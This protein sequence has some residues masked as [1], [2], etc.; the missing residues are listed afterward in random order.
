[1]RKLI[2]LRGAQGCG[3]T[4]LVKDYQPL[5]VSF[6]SFRELHAPAIPTLD[7]DTSLVLSTGAQKKSVQAALGA[8][9]ERMAL[10]MSVVVDNMNLR[11][12]DQAD[13]VRLAEKYQYEVLLVDVQ[14]DI[15][16]EELLRRN[17]TRGNKRIEEA[18]LLDFAAVGRERNLHPD[19]REISRDQLHAE[20]VAR[21][22]WVD[23]N[24]FNR[25][26]VI[27]DIH[28]CADALKQATERELSDGGPIAWVFLGD[29]FDRGPDAAR[30]FQHVRQELGH[31][32][33]A[34]FFIEGN[35]ET[36]MRC[37]ILQDATFS[38]DTLKSREDIHAKGFSDSD[39][40]ELLN[41]TRPFLRFR[42]AGKRF[43]ACHGGVDRRTV[44]GARD[45]HLMPDH[46]FIHG[47]SD[48]GRTYRKRS[49]YEHVG[50]FL[51]GDDSEVTQ[52]HG[53]RNGG[54]DDE[55]L[56][57]D[58]VPGIYN[59]EQGVEEGGHLALAVIDR[60]G[61]ITVRRYTERADEHRA[62]E[63][64]ARNL[65][66]ELAAHPDIHA[67]DLGNGIT[68]YNFTRDA[69]RRG[70][71]DKLSTSA[72][73]LFMRGDKV[74]ARGYEKFFNLGERNGFTREQVLE[75]FEYPVLVKSKVN[76]FL[77]IVAAVDGKLV[78]YT[79]GG[80]TPYAKAGQKAFEWFYEPHLRQ[81][82][83]RLLTQLNVS[84]TFEVVLN[85]DPHIVAESEGVH[86]LD[87]I[88]ND[89]Q[90]RLANAEALHAIEG[91]VGWGAQSL[92][93]RAEN[94]DELAFWLD[95]FMESKDEGAVFTDAAGRW[96]KVKSQHYLRI[97][98]MRSALL[99][100][101]TGT[102]ET[103][104]SRFTAEESV[105]RESGVWDDLPDYLEKTPSGQMA[106]RIPDIVEDA[107]L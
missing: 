39:I 85:N 104:G 13:W 88:V 23:L 95:H 21:T 32:G 86:F 92:A 29:L 25:V 19:V 45:L 55:R 93:Q 67:K 69:F 52:L 63:P 60:T 89:L 14:G 42:F 102:G 37:A 50:E 103:L 54:F 82:L 62:E 105:L 56:P 24:G 9:E 34:V 74:V 81:D 4:T 43:F 15:T 64:K 75:E 87:A 84:L 6:D 31:Y 76:G 72:R 94:R 17:R 22:E 59:L 66:E 53:H 77:M 51:A 106:L 35:H 107:D 27:G 78:Y 46:F 38:K 100:V 71:W 18:L 1:M 33:D 16:D 57:E 5:V 96:T 68:A 48:R 28:S 44:E 8:A 20:I 47:I 91:I 41:S 40:L 80:P 7:G 61:N 90:F 12:K 3:K 26:V 49:T 30:V 73:G 97:K 2:L 58:T 65:S 36:N 98:S 79:K 99:R 83:A 70:R 10:G 101:A 11:V